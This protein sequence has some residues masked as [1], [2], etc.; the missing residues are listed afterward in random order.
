M[1]FQNSKW[2]LKYHDAKFALTEH[3]LGR[4]PCPRKSS[5]SPIQEAGSEVSQV[6]PS[7][8]NVGKP[9]EHEFDLGITRQGKVGHYVK[10]EVYGRGITRQAKVGMNV[11]VKAYSYCHLCCVAEVGHLEV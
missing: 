3:A 6:V 1:D 10:V 11:N 5:H 4:V 2:C 9:I 8:G 7:V